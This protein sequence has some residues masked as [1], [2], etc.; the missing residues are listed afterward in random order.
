MQYSTKT[1]F[2]LASFFGLVTL[3]L[4][5]IAAPNPAPSKSFFDYEAKDIHGDKLALSKYKGQ[6]ILVVNTASQCGFTPQFADLETIYQKYKSKGFL[7]LAFPSNDFK[8]DPDSGSQIEKFSKEKYKINFPLMEKASVKGPEKQPVYQFL[9][10]SKSGVLFKEVAWNFEKF[11][12]NRKGEVVGRWN[13]M[14]KPTDDS[15]TKS[16][17]KSLTEKP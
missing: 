8:Q 7:V 14:S 16:I 13:S 5:L 17:E 4:K 15:I 6:V 12:V 2:I 10:N 3:P 9:V 11:L 1:A